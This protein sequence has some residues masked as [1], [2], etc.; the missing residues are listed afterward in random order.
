M[1]LDGTPRGRSRDE[2]PLRVGAPTVIA[3]AVLAVGLI[4]LVLFM[5]QRVRDP[6]DAAAAGSGVSGGSARPGNPTS[7]N[8]SPGGASP[9]P[10]SPIQVRAIQRAQRIAW[11]G[12]VCRARG[13]VTAAISDLPGLAVQ[14]AFA[15]VLSPQQEQDRLQS[16]LDALT[17]EMDGLGRALGRAPIDYRQAN[18][19]LVAVMSEVRDFGQARDTAAAAIASIG[20]ASGPI[21]LV[22]AIR[23]AATSV[24]DAYQAGREVL[25]TLDGVTSPT[26][27]E[28][29][30]A[31]NAATPCRTR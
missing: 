31:F 6:S 27:G 18:D 8:P 16:G 3:V 21:D 13:R 17:L 22:D 10:L 19:A 14:D 28:L 29:R 1:S 23:T 15:A 4:G 25:T 24:G 26:R 2:R 7:G 11:A 9:A 5:G 30:D 12:Q 20:Q